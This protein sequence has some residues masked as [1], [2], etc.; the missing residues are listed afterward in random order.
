M[1]DKNDAWISF[2]FVFVFL[3]VFALFRHLIISESESLNIAIFISSSC[4][5]VGRLAFSRS[6]SS[7]LF[8]HCL[9][10]LAEI[11]CNKIRARRLQE[12]SK[13]FFLP[14][15]SLT[16]LLISCT[17]SIEKLNV[18]YAYDFVS[19]DDKSCYLV[20]MT[21][22][23]IF[24]RGKRKQQFIQNHLAHTKTGIARLNGMYFIWC[25][26]RKSSKIRNEMK[27]KQQIK[28]VWHLITPLSSFRSDISHSHTTN[29]PEFFSA[30]LQIALQNTRT[31]KICELEE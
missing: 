9:W 11:I 20:S 19:I 21:K 31:V 25:E 8:S 3:L 1:I 27:P 23:I 30:Y 12:K 7:Q 13:P 10:S 16:M 26:T 15:F 28:F 5:S 18:I 14:I 22:Q 2:H 4:L 6:L 24:G 17:W 29:G